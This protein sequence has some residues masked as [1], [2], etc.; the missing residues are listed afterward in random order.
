VDGS[1]VGGSL[2]P[3]IDC[4]GKS[5]GDTSIVVFTNHADALAFA[6]TQLSV[7][8]LGPVGEVVGANW[9]VNTIPAYGR[10]AAAALGGKL[11]V[12][13]AAEK[14]QRAAEARAKK[15]AAAEARK[16]AAA[17]ARARLRNTVEFIVTGSSA[18]VTYG[19]ANSNMQASVPLDISEHIPVSP[20]AYYA[21]T[22][23]LNGNGT[24]SCTIKIGGRPISSATASGSYN[25]ATCEAVW[26]PING[27]WQDANSG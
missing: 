10:K 26:D 24:V 11:M 6:R 12:S 5:E 25:I 7:T 23:Q 17:R 13:Q 15:R 14:Y 8:N 3:Y 27:V 1:T 21:I 2:N 22:A 18:D 19:A 16:K 9:V 20:P 4:T